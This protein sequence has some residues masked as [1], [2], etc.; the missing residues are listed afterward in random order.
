MDCNSYSPNKK[1]PLEKR[2][3]TDCLC[4]IG[5]SVFIV[6]WIVL[7]NYAYQNS[8]QQ[9]LVNPSD[10]AGQVCG[11]NKNVTDK[12]FLFFFDITECTSLMIFVHGCQTPQVCVDRC[13]DADWSVKEVLDGKQSQIDWPA[14][15][16][17]LIC[18]SP[19]LN[20]L[21]NS[22]EK[23]KNF[24]SSN[25]C[26]KYYIKSTSLLNYC[27]PTLS[28]TESLKAFMKT[29]NI[30]L[31]NVID[32]TTMVEW[33]KDSKENSKLI[34]DD[35][36]NN[37][38]YIIGGL[39]IAI[40]FSLTYILLL[41]WFSWIMI[42]LS[43]LAI[44]GLL[45]FGSYESYTRYVSFDS[46]A[47]S[48]TTGG[49]DEIPTDL[50]TGGRQSWTNYVN[51]KLN[52]KSTWLVFT[53]VSSIA[54]VVL[55]LIIVFLRKR[56]RLSIALIVEGSRAILEIKTSLVFP[57]FQWVL[58]LAVLMWFFGV[59]IYLS[60]MKLYVFKVKGLVN[61]LDCVCNNSYYKVNVL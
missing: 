5:F 34:A 33:L 48:S 8:D 3:C 50:L 16:K 55:L 14:V 57:L 24:T 46:D 4:F 1:K 42:W 61:D 60:S 29:N 35:L 20:K 28:D 13:P 41:R 31:S 17:S 21:V 11:Y 43:L 51:E 58:Y 53:V 27:V 9:V 36:I 7:A 6:C 30:V 54:F 39:L 37:Y 26:T 23:L 19:D 12:P 56:I 47:D 59:A 40:L 38:R 49:E 44:V 2:S 25:L 15:Q 18:V 22:V 45:G 52:T 10:S 32:G